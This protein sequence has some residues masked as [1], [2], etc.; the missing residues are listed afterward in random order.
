MVILDEFLQLSQHHWLFTHCPTELFARLP[1]SNIYLKLHSIITLLFKYL[2]LLEFIFEV[3]FYIERVK[4]LSSHS[5]QHYF[6]FHSIFKKL[7]SS[8]SFTLTIFQ[9]VIYKLSLQAK[10]NFEN[11]FLCTNHYATERYFKSFYIEQLP[12]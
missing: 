7:L 10:F 8:K 6:R 2:R 1:N 3:I 9:R 5:I 12:N 4:F 11:S